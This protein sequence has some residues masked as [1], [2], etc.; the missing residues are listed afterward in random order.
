MCGIA[1]LVEPPGSVVD[2]GV[3]ERMG[4]VL[5]HR[6]PDEGRTWRAPGSLAHI[7]LSHRRLSILDHAGGK[8]PMSSTDDRITV[9]FNG[10]I[11]N[12]LELRR[13]LV[14]QGHEFQT[15]HSDTEV[16]VH[17]GRAWGAE[18]CARLSGMFAFAVVDL[19][20][21]TLLLARDPMGKKPLYVA[22]PAFFDDGKPRVAFASEL[23]ALETLPHAKRDVDANALARYLAFDFVPDPDCIYQGVFKLEPGFLVEV[24][25]E[26]PGAWSSLKERA[27]SFRELSFSRARIPESHQARV[28]ELR[29]RIEAA[30]ATRMVADVP[31]GI[32][33]SGGIDSSVVAALAA[34]R[35]SKV[36][37]FSIAF[38]EPSF[39]E[40]RWSRMMAAHIGSTHHEEVLDENTLVDVMPRLAAHLSEPFADHSV[41]PTH[42]LSTFARKRVTV[43]LGGDGG[44]ELFL[45]Y[46]TFLL[47]AARPRALDTALGLPGDPLRRASRLALRA[48][49]KLPVSHAD[50][51][52]DF[53][54]Q[55]ALDGITEPRALRRHQLFLTGATDERLRALLSADTRARLDA[56]DLLSP[57]DVYEARARAAGA[58]DVFDVLTFGYARTYLG[59]GVIQKVDRASMAS[60]L[61]VRAPLLDNDVVDF[62]L[63]LPSSDKLKRFQTKAILKEAARGLIPDEIID[64]KKKG[65][66][67]PVAAWLLGPLRPLVDELLSPRAIADDGLLDPGAVTRLVDEHMQRKVNHRKTLWAILMLRLWRTR[68]RS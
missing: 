4:A 26:D 68:A 56:Q 1:G 29:A 33:L 62:A 21:R 30:V 16:L 6:G 39:D 53:K 3:L 38:K 42:L 63:A 15:D 54:V 36:E 22:T 24:P 18:M 2:D 35:S 61:E 48:A 5:R 9:C 13:E 44:D 59:A 17:G 66:G 60:S 57:L 19:D 45:G 64:R 52:L 11:Y 51:A 47:E 46:P 28:D 34:R 67:M 37:T 12:H 40:S 8:Q 7:G 32:L 58:R 25:L 23:V 31:V 10:Q 14:A 55:R 49:R 50:L 20:R 65:F 41:I 43:A 27:R